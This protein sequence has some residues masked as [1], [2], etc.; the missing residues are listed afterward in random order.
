MSFDNQESG[1]QYA[2]TFFSYGQ[3]SMRGGQAA[4]SQWDPSLAQSGDFSPSQIWIS[5]GQIGT[6]NL[7]TVEA[8]WQVRLSL[9]QLV[10]T[11]LLN[12][13]YYS[14]LAYELTSSKSLRTDIKSTVMIDIFL[15]KYSYYKNIFS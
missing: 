13:T 12:T 6:T 9:S 1:H 3:A 4:I 2:I 11:L 14:V 8:G 5:A 7:R 15:L 10:L